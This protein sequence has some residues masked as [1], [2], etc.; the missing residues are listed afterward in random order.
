MSQ[1]EVSVASAPHI[2]YKVDPLRVWIWMG[3]FSSCCQTPGL[4]FPLR[5]QKQLKFLPLE[6]SELYCQF[7]ELVLQTFAKWLS[8]KKL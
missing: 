7:C 8:G 5:L 1:R 6:L 4:K 2:I 3:I